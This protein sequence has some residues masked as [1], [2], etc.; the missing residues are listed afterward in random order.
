MA[1]LDRDL[2]RVLEDLA[3]EFPLL[4]SLVDR[5]PG[6]QKRLPMPDGG[7]GYAYRPLLSLVHENGAAPIDT[8]PDAGSPSGPPGDAPETPD[9]PAAAPG[10]PPSRTAETD[11]R[12]GAVPE[13]GATHRR[14]RYG[15]SLQF[16]RRDDDEPGRLVENTV[17]INEAHPAFQRAQASRSIGY[18]IA[19]TVALSLAP[20]A[21]AAA[22]EHTFITRFLAEWGAAQA[23]RP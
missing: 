17:W 16:E 7:D 18:H 19:L 13:P 1:R 6:G 21:V 20:L 11:Q 5:R 2:A 14:A 9:A 10:V 23:P 4:H 3:D 8:A 15:L 22:E 12:A